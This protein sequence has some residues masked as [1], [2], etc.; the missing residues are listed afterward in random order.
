MDKIIKK[1]IHNEKKI[2]KINIKKKLY[3]KITIYYY[4]KKTL[5]D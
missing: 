1:Y 4:K 3:I 5:F 2:I